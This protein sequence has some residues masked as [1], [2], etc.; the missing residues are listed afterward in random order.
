M[1]PNAYL[2]MADTESRHWWFLARRVLL[3]SSIRRLALPSDAQIAEIG[4]GTGG[5]LE[6]LSAFGRVSA[7][8]MDATAS[9]IANQKT[10]DRRDIRPGFCPTSIP[11]S[12]EKFDLICLFD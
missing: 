2:E 10:L 11:R 12:D 7:L 4:S 6:M 9:S 1:D 8:E 5:K 3:C